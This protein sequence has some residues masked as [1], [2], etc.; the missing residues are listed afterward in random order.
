MRLELD[1]PQVVL[2]EAEDLRAQTVCQ[3]VAGALLPLADWL[4]RKWLLLFRS[5]RICLASGSRAERYSWERSHCLRFVGDGTALPDLCFEPA[6]RDAIRLR[7]RSDGGEPERPL[8]FLLSSNSAT[9][10]R[11]KVEVPL[12]ALVDG[13]LARLRLRAPGAP[14]LVSLDDSWVRARSAA[15][16]DHQPARLAAFAGLDWSLLEETQRDT[17]RARGGKASLLFEQALAA[18]PPNE[19][20]H[21]DSLASALTQAAGLAELGT[22]W[23]ALRKRVGR[24]QSGLPWEV[25]W[26]C[27]HRLRRAMGKDH[28][29]P[30]SPPSLEP[31]ATS[32]DIET[33][34]AV[35]DGR[36]PV[37]FVADPSKDN[38]F[39]R[40]RDVWPVLFGEHSA[41]TAWGSVFSRR[42]DADF[43]VARAF[44]A[45]LLAPIAGIKRRI[46]GAADEDDIPWLAHELGGAPEGCVRHQLENHKLLVAP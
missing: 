33:A 6:G 20:V 29:E 23:D 13:V 22:S 7:W 17:W 45:E 1:D 25:G 15:H 34:V 41:G 2:T 27:A 37:R 10:L 18:L 39:K 21:A 42:S 26:D 30:F 36:E 40:A 31:V 8:R 16:A 11:G 3:D 35:V 38:R 43:S 19:P 5:P 9:L 28:D 12:A 24:A 46:A 44:S 4:A 14:A 32:F